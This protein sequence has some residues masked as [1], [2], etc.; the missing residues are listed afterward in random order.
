MSDDAVHKR[1]ASTPLLNISTITIV[2]LSSLVL[3][4]LP[5]DTIIGSRLI[6]VRQQLSRQFNTMAKVAPPRP[7]KLYSNNR[8]PLE[9]TGLTVDAH[10]QLVPD[11]LWQKRMPNTKRSKSTC[12]IN[13]IGISKLIQYPT[14]S[15]CVIV[16]WESPRY[17]FRR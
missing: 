4:L 12:K 17:G 1:R 3:Y 7:I 14:P 6:Q 16:E 9:S 5:Q 11:W 8:Y 15:T 2:L 13:Q 10:S